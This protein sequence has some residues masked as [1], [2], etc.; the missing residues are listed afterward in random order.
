MRAWAPILAVAA[1]PAGCSDDADPVRRA[2]S[3]PAA[4]PT[5]GPAPEYGGRCPVTLPNRD[6]PADAE[7]F[8]HGNGSI[9]VA[10]WPKGRLPAGILPDGSAWAEILEDGTIH[11]KLGWWRGEEGYLR[12]EGE[13]LDAT[14]PPLTANIP[15]GYGFSGFQPVGRMFP[16]AGCWRVVARLGDSSLAFVVRVRKIGRP[17]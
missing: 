9:A 11:A 4:A 14:A 7:G 5:A 10:L 13:R 2:A 17:N 8:N 15:G 16:T 3:K 12:I 6:A 1:V